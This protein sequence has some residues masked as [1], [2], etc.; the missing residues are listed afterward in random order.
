MSGPFLIGYAILWAT[1]MRA[2][3]VKARLLP[4][5]CTRCGLRYERSE[6][7]QPVCS[8]QASTV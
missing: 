2:L 4:A 8:C 5:T 3:L 1:L 7:G 6:L